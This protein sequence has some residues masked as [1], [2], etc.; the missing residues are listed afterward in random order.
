MIHHIKRS[1]NTLLFRDILI[2]QA[3][4]SAKNP[5]GSYVLIFTSS[6]NIYTM[7]TLFLFLTSPQYVFP[8]PQSFCSNIK[9]SPIQLSFWVFPLGY[10]QWQL[11][12]VFLPEKFHGHRTLVF[13][14]PWDHKQLHMTKQTYKNKFSPK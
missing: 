3:L 8:E 2:F 13:Y 10:S 11:T 4:V 12:L 5:L 7:C 1:I 14:S 6:P 9:Y